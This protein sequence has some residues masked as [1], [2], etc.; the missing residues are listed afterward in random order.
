M[1]FV[2]DI[3][4]STG[5]DT[6]IG[7]DGTFGEDK[8]N[9][10]TDADWSYSGTGAL[11]IS[12]SSHGGVQHETFAY[13]NDGFD[14]Y[15]GLHYTWTLTA[16]ASMNGEEVLNWNYT[17]NH[18]GFEASASLW[19]EVSGD[20]SSHEL[21]SST[22]DGNYSDIS[23]TNFDW[24]GSLTLNLS[25]GST[26][27]FFIE[28]YNYDS[29]EVMHGSL[30]LWSSYASLNGGGG[31]DV[32]E[33]TNSTVLDTYFAQASNFSELKIDNAESITLASNFDATGIST[34]DL[35]N[36][37]NFFAMDASGS[38]SDLY[39]TLT[40]GEFN[41]SSLAGGTGV[42]ELQLSGGN[43]N[44]SVSDSHLTNIDAVSMGTN[45]TLSL[46]QGD[47]AADT[48]TTNAIT[49]QGNALLVIGNA[50]D[51]VNLYD[52]LSGHWSNTGTG[53]ASVNNV[54]HSYQVYTNSATGEHVDVE[55]AVH[56]NVVS[57]A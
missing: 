48:K 30:D 54:S 28:G 7:S 27:T 50:S 33:L 55:S 56:V 1:H 24:L 4:G 47:I 52:G 42:T 25:A 16:T 9:I 53:S 3:I 12:T 32:L 44:L 10:G 31:T 17:G 8:L 37:G 43:T 2:S 45:S 34:I 5:N 13:N 40:S 22:A 18:D 21:V 19:Y 11:S 6:F 49:H 26:I 15:A 29:G 35:S 41:G 36:D 39:I 20:N 14:V 51:T 38:T 57:T 23:W 46:A